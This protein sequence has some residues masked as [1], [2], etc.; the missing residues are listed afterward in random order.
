MSYAKCRD[1][2]IDRLLNGEAFF[3]DSPVVSRCRNCQFF[4]ARRKQCKLAQHHPRTAKVFFAPHALKHFAQYQIGQANFFP[5]QLSIKP[6]CFRIPPA[7]QVIHPDGC[8]DDDHAV[9]I[10]CFAQVVILPDCLP[11]VFSLADAGSPSVYEAVRVA[12]TLLPPSRAWFSLRCSSSLPSLADHRSLCWC[13]SLGSS[14]C[15][16]LTLMCTSQFRTDLSR[17]SCA[18]GAIMAVRAHHVFRRNPGSS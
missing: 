9:S 10:R 15:T 5:A 12:A 3:A 16:Y 13:A 7:T 14:M 8:V 18:T 11:T 1:Q 2:A 6:F 4:S 17:V